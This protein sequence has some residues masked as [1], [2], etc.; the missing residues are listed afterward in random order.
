ML[1]WKL[2]RWIPRRGRCQRCRRLHCRWDK[3]KSTKTGYCRRITPT[4]TGGGAEGT[5][6]TSSQERKIRFRSETTNFSSQMT[7]IS[8]AFG[9][10]RG[11]KSARETRA[12]GVLGRGRAGRLLAKTLRTRSCGGLGLRDSI[13]SSWDRRTF[14]FHRGSSYFFKKCFL[15]G[16]CPR[17]NA[18]RT[19][20]ISA[21]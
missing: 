16:T 5:G 13:S 8:S 11:G 10:W 15:S 17:A 12:V 19:F 4:I 20:L 1:C 7:L 2:E 6:C 21:R 9:S 18:L 3:R 14:R